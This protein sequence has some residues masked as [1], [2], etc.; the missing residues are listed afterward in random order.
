M[1][2][3]PAAGAPARSDA[4]E[5][6]SVALL[7]EHRP[8]VTELKALAAELDIGL[9]WHY[10]LDLSWIVARLPPSPGTVLD[11]GAGTG[12]LQW[13]LA[14]QGWNVVSVDRVS[15]RH[16]ESR[17][18]T[19]YRVRGLRPMDLARLPSGRRALVRR[20]T[21]GVRRLQ[22]LVVAVRHGYRPRIAT[23]AG[24]PPREAPAGSGEVLIYNQDLRSLADIAD[25]SI[26]EIV[27]VSALEHNTPDALQEVVAELFRVLRPG[28]R[29]IATL[30][31]SNREDWYHEP[32][33]AWCYSEATMRRI[34]GL[35]ASVTSNYEQYDRLLESLRASAELRTNLAAFY[36]RS[37]ANGMPW[38][39]WEP[40]YQTLGVCKVKPGA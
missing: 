1:L 14:E 23:P 32:A 5:I 9:G 13:Y 26:D 29:L 12:I 21:G 10:L 15:R 37:G 25:G 33:R 28:G 27:S 20:L 17:F 8:M 36:Y 3:R 34:F 4:L 24:R 11:A 39:K 16:L 2:Q 6:L 18:R 40:Q 35:D 7:D 19:R 30:V 22:S 31:A 38:G